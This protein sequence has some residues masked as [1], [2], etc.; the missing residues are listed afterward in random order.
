M[1]IPKYWASG[2]HTLTDPRGANH[3]FKATGWSDSSEEEARYKARKNAEKIARALVL[4]NRRLDS[5]TYEDRPLREEIVE[6]LEFDDGKRSLITRNSYGALIL[7]SPSTMFVDIDL[8]AS[9]GGGWL[10]KLFSRS[11][12]TPEQAAVG[13]ISKLAEQRSWSARVYRTAAGLR[14]VFLH[15]YFD[16][17]SGQTEDVMRSIGA[18][19]M[20]LQ[21]CQKQECFRARL[22]PKYWR[23]SA[24][25]PPSRFPWT[26]NLEMERYRDWEKEYNSI[27]AP[28]STCHLLTEFK[29]G[30]AVP[31]I[32]EEL[33]VHD[34]YTRSAEALKLA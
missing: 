14:A 20:Y 34:R 24:D 22:T 30:R 17:K 33:R 23:C 26:D 6:Q 18:D 12:E 13:R 8:P 15:E 10:G 1:R 31:A 5:Y 9:S 3:T 32:E 28:Y 19:P 27:C 4:E 7:N 11:S 21:L 29:H 16:P 25:R 2:E